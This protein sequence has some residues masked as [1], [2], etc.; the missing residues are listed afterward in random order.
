M[1]VGIITFHASY[2]CGSMLQAFALQQLLS[3][4]NVQCEIIDFCNEGSRKM[5]A[6]FPQIRLQKKQSG[7]KWWL[8]TIPYC[9]LIKRHNNQYKHFSDLYLKK[10]GKKYKSCYELE[11]ADFNYTHYFAGS[12]QIWNIK[13]KDADDAYFLSFVK[14]GKKVAYAVSLGATN[15][16]LT[17][18]IN[19][20]K[21]KKYISDFEL[22]SVR[23]RNAIS[24]IESLY[25]KNVS[26]QLD[27]TLL[28]SKEEWE[29]YF[30]LD[31]RIVEEDYI[32]Y[33]AFTY[34]P[35][36]NQIVR[37]ISE[38]MKLPVY[39]IDAKAWG[40]HNIRKEGFKL[41]KESGP[42]AFLN[43]MKHAKLCLTTS[44]H[45]TVFSIIFKKKFWFIESSMHSVNDDRV[46]TLTSLLCLEHRQ[47]GKPILETVD[48]YEDINFN[49][50]DTLLQPLKEGSLK[51][52]MEGLK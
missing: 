9:I 28:L 35:E 16:L 51:F 22:I 41:C 34:S 39:I 8:R 46:S 14:S 21:Y 37:N 26:I 42:I 18:P 20:E 3:K 30:K 36:V 45:G 2:N 1:K 52:I 19:I 23:E 25:G 7:L 27:P 44:F 15:I 31:E 50:V 49:N 48:L 4:N 24:Q 43:L 10:S 47:V 5:Y 6:V 12:D 29:S 38:R 11:R 17:T 13:C 32:F 33:Y 40:L